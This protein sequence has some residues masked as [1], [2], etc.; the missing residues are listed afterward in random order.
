MKSSKN[1]SKLNCKAVKSKDLQL[2]RLL[3]FLPNN[4]QT[5]EGVN[6]F[7]DWLRNLKYNLQAIPMFKVQDL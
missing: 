3:T 1:W 5:K 7:A 4:L 2:S 6:L